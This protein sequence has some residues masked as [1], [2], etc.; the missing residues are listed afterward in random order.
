MSFRIA[1]W[2]AETD[3]LYGVGHHVRKTA[4]PSKSVNND[5]TDNS[6]ACS[7]SHPAPS[8]SPCLLNSLQDSRL[9]RRG[10]ANEIP[11]F[12]KLSV[13]LRENGSFC[14]FFFKVS[15]TL[16]KVFYVNS[17]EIL[18]NFLDQIK[19]FCNKNHTTLTVTE[20]ESCNQLFAGLVFVF[21]PL[22][23]IKPFSQLESSESIF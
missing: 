13:V 2:P 14:W 5:R 22:Y 7:R 18:L 10:L 11:K 4:C 12:V 9:N 17:N 1:F 6:K 16:P 20:V 15:K 8:A 3:M 23:E 19:G 21:P